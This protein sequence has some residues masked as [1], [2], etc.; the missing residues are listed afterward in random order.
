MPEEET[1]LDALA[2]ESATVELSNGSKVTLCRLKARQ[3][4]VLLRI[5]TRGSASVLGNY[6][7][8]NLKTPEE[9]ATQLLGLLIFAIPEAPEATFEFLR[10]MIDTEFDSKAGKVS[11]NY[12]NAMLLLEEPEM[13]DVIVLL[14]AI[15]RQ[16]SK[17]L[18]ALGNRLR[19]LIRTTTPAKKTE[20]LA[21]P[22]SV[23][24]S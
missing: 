22:D 4:F 1:E 5:I 24:A 21:T 9:F 15:V 16:E 19:A 11:A 6:N 20:P 7:W 23:P 14:E 8:G 18:V 10:S 13:E 3:F 12:T 2:P 17:D